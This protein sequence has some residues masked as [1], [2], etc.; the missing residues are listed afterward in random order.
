[1]AGSIATGIGG[2]VVLVASGIVVA[3]ALGPENRGILALVVVIS[4]I[5]TQVG[6]LGVPVSVTYW[7]ATEQRNPRSLLRGLRRFRN[8]QL[9]AILAAQAV[10]ILVV[11]EPRSP[12]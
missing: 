6:S 9:G 1:M 3:R 8:M 10:L 7:I 11:L 2:Q 5:A 12:S 4:A